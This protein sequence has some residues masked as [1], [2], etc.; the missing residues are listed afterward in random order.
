[1]LPAPENEDPASKLAS[2]SVCRV[3]E[4]ERGGGAKS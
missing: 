4:R 1:M 3:A 2:E